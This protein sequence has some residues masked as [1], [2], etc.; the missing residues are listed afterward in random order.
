[1]WRFPI[2]IVGNRDGPKLSPAETANVF[3]LMFRHYFGGRLLLSRV[4]PSTRGATSPT[5]YLGPVRRASRSGIRLHH[6]VP[7]HQRA[8]AA[9]GNQRDRPSLGQA[10]GEADTL[11]RQ[12]SRVPRR[13][14]PAHSG[15]APT[16]YVN[17]YRLTR[18]F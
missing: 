2:P 1:M 10:F 3:P 12:N 16:P 17:P 5:D 6:G 13:R 18:L 11:R 15:G 8:P 14:V 9:T 4:G 7:E